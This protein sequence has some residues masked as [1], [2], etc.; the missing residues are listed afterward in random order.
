MGKKPVKPVCWPWDVTHLVATQH[1]NISENSNIERGITGVSQ[2]THWH[3]SAGLLVN[4]NP[5]N[6]NGYEQASGVSLLPGSVFVL[7]SAFINPMHFGCSTLWEGCCCSFCLRV[8]QFSMTCSGLWQYKHSL[9]SVSELRNLQSH[10]L[11]R[12]LNRDRKTALW[13]ST[14]SLACL[15]GE[16]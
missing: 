10:S 4:T 3:R 7:G 9:S 6:T 5:F 1:S 11:M 12:L 2:N 15:T 16:Q 8:K 14:N 13:V